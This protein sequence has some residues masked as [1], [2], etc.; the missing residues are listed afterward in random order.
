MGKLDARRRLAALHQP[1]RSARV[2]VGQKGR[3]D[4][5]IQGFLHDLQIFDVGL[6]GLAGPDTGRDIALRLG[7]REEEKA[8]QP[9]FIVIGNS[10]QAFPALAH[11]VAVRFQPLALLL[12]KAQE[13]DVLR[14]LAGKKTGDRVQAKTVHTYVIQPEIHYR[15]ISSRRSGLFRFKSGMLPPENCSS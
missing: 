1:H 12:Q 14:V 9:A 8:F 2:V 4:V 11:Q 7:S 10:A 3:Q 5:P 6:R 13:G 15:M